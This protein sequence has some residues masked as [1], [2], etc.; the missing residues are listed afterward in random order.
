MN[1]VDRITAVAELGARLEGLRGSKVEIVELVS[2]RADAGFERQSTVRAQFSFTVQ[3]TAWQM[4]G[5]HFVLHGEEGQCFMI[6]TTTQREKT[7]VHSVF[8]QTA[9]Q[10]WQGCLYF[11]PRWRDFVVVSFFEGKTDGFETN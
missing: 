8:Q 5:G 4:S 11:R 1:D 6:G 9:S 3:S 2:W 10:I 7:T